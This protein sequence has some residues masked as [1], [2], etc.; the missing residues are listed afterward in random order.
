[1]SVAMSVRFIDNHKLNINNADR[2][3]NTILLGD[4]ILEITVELNGIL[5]SC[6]FVCATSSPVVYI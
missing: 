6:L 2:Q 3:G 5:C 4:N 1:M